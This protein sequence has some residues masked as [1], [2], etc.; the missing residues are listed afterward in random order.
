MNPMGY[1]PY[2]SSGTDDD[3]PSSQNRGLRG[4]SFSGNGRASAGPFPY[5]RPH[6]DLES[7]VHLVEQEAYTGVLRAFKVQSDALSWEKESLISELRKELRV[8]DEE[9]RELLN[10][11]NEDGAI[12]GMRELRQG[13]GTP[14][15]L[16]RGSRVL[17]DGEPGPTAKRQRPS[18]L[19]P[20]HSSGLQSPVMS[21]HSVPSSSKW[22]P[23]SASRGKRAKSTTPLALPSMD[24]TSLISRK[25]FTRWPDDNNFY[26]ATITRYNP[27]TGEHA[28]VYDMGKTTESWESVRLCDMRPE[29]IRWERDDQG[30]S[31]RDGWGPSGPLLNRNQSNNGRGR[32]SQNEHPNKYGP[33]QNGINRNIGEI[34]VPNTQSV[35]IEVERVLSNPSMHE[36]EKAKK[37]LTDQEQSLLDAIASLDDASDSES[38]DK[39]MEARMG[40]GGDHTGRNGIAC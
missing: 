38:E 5:A 23:S 32:L 21:S 29:D 28:L 33:P 13:G 39:A 3:L 22:G 26:E 24:P 40:S 25:V 30:I 31:N 11:V 37:L 4:R 7:Q 15:G 9:H 2:D 6:N 35:V 1:R 10:K 34:D 20:S 8:S 16:H 27:A 12:R 17:H 14:S 36:I 19:M 18:H